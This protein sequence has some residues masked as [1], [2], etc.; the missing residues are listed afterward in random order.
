MELD[1]LFPKINSEPIDIFPLKNYFLV[2]Y[3]NFLVLGTPI[4]NNL[5][6]TFLENSYIKLNPCYYKDWKISFDKIAKEIANSDLSKN[7]NNP[8]VIVEYFTFS[9]TWILDNKHFIIKLNNHLQNK[10]Q[11]ILDVIE[12]YNVY[13]GIC[14]LFFKP[15]CLPPFI[16]FMFKVIID[17]KPLLIIKRVKNIQNALQFVKKLN[18]FEDDYPKTILA[19][20][21]VLRFQNEL[22][23]HKQFCDKAFKIAQ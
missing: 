2:A 4:V 18:L 3:P 12:F 5:Q 14:A 16:I 7:I 8:E 15:M 6:I 20:E 22:I 17:T 1:S 9:I 21:N 11:I 13:N 10:T 19:A 23:L